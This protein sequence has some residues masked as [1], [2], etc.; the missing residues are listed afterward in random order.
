[1]PKQLKQTW[2]E[3]PTK[4]RTMSLAA[5]LRSIT[6]RGRPAKAVVFMSSCDG[7]EFHHLLLGACFEQAACEPLLACP[8]L[9]LHGDMLQAERTASFLQ[10]SQAQTGVLLCTDVAA[11]GLD[12]PS[13]THILQYDPPGEAAEYVHRVGRTARIGQQGSALLFL[14]PAEKVYATM[15]QQHGIQVSEEKLDA[16]LGWL[17][18][19]EEGGRWVG[20]HG[21]AAASCGVWRAGYMVCCLSLQH[22]CS[23]RLAEIQYSRVAPHACNPVPALCSMGLQ[24]LCCVCLAPLA[25]CAAP[26]PPRPRCRAREKDKLVAAALLHRKLMAVVDRD[27]ACKTLAADAFRCAAAHCWLLDGLVWQCSTQYLLI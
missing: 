5:A 21:F 2:V 3:V 20:C 26:P 24:P 9:K 13:V 11:R 22:T 23:S 18:Q 14:Q 4:L 17:P 16:L 1:M 8:L 25:D 19:L 27:K 12:F 7:V 10:F 15:L 6:R